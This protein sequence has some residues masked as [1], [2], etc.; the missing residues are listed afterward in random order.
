MKGVHFMSRFF[1]KKRS[2]LKSYTPGE[3][4]SLGEFLKLNTNESPFPP[5]HSAVKAASSH[6]P[7]LNLYNDT[8]CTR[9]TEVFARHKDVLEENVIFSNGSD[10]ILAFCYLAFC[11][12]EGG[13][14]YPDI[15]YG[16][17]DVFS[18]LFLTPCEV[19]PLDKDFKIN[20]EHYYNKGKTV[21]IANPN[22]PTGI[23]LS[24]TEIEG[25]IEHNRDNIVI[26]DE[27]YVDFGAES[28][29][30]LT[31]KYDNLIVVGTFSKSRNMAGA[32]LGYA[33]ACKELIADLNR[34]KFSFNPYNVNSITQAIGSASIEEDDYYKE[35]I[36]EVI[37]ARTEFVK[38]LDGM[39]FNTLPSLANFVFTTTDKM[40]GELLFERLKEHKILVRHF[41]TDR[42]KNH[43]RI[44]IGTREQMQH[45]A[46]TLEK[47][48][49]GAK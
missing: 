20:P 6:V 35:C 11:D 48:L 34:V 40:E 5:P 39:S 18:E 44:S 8:K 45:V 49:G 47:I 27:A 42:L 30:P 36:G 25:I 43:L 41:K 2:G 22:A 9:L 1:S 38:A 17:Y 14:C 7:H 24:L 23:A 46:K 12:D 28:A 10:E 32:R 26:I 29:A 31:K 3:Q 33:I 4:P 13:I 37:A 15:S 16:F 21:L 19:I